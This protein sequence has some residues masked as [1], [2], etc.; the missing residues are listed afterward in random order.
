MRTELYLM[1]ALLG[2]TLWLLT[3]VLAVF[4]VVFAFYRDRIS[5]P[6]LAYWAY[7]CLSI[8]LL[9]PSLSSLMALLGESGSLAA[10]LTVTLSPL[11]LFASMVLLI[12]SI[13]P[14]P[15]GDDMNIQFA[16]SAGQGPT[17]APAIGTPAPPATPSSEDAS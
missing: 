2:S 10:M 6:R 16:D 9:M 8:G 1:T 12:W 17:A 13:L 11:G 5:S 3:L 15:R 7:Y 4:Y 14:H